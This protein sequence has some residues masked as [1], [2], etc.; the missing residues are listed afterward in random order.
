M[1]DDLIRENNRDENLPALRRFDGIGRRIE[2]VSFHPS[3]LKSDAAPT[4]LAPSHAYARPGEER[5]QLAYSICL[6]TTVKADICVRLLAPQV[7]SRS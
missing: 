3:Y 2:E 4:E 1:L 7:L 6:R 5:V